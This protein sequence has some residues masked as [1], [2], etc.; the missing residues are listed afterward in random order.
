VGTARRAAAEDE[1]LLEALQPLL[2]LP[3]LY[4]RLVFLALGFAAITSLAAAYSETL[5]LPAGARFVLVPAV[6]CIVLVGLRHREWGRRALV[7]WVAGIIA[8]CIYDGLRLGL[9]LLGLWEDPIPRIG[10]ML[11]VDPNANWIWGYIWRFLGNGGGMGLAFA[12]LPWRGVRFGIAYGTC[13]C[14]GLF[15]VLALWPVAQVHFFPLTPVVAAGA[16]A[17]HWVYGAVLGA[18]T[19]RWLPPVRTSE[20]GARPPARK[21]GRANPRPRP[22]APAGVTR[23]PASPEGPVRRR[24]DPPGGPGRA[25][26]PGPPRPGTGWQGRPGAGAPT[27]YPRPPVPTRRAE[28][29]RAG[30]P[31]PSHLR[32]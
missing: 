26:Q 11:F 30:T 14:L 7:G 12:M 8:T 23:A 24:P 18:L 22:V 16:M 17:G 31:R 10:Q 29:A 20:I 3:S 9:M 6:A 13:I 5:P 2:S 19:A 25:G 27:T 28:G 32:S 21:S 4:P 15:A 1:R